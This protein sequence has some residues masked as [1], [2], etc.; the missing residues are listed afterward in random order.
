MKKPTGRHFESLKNVRGG[1]LRDGCVRLLSEQD[2]GD[3]FEERE[4]GAV[5][6]GRFRSAGFDFGEDLAELGV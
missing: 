5:P 4:G 1:F 2:L 3:V 6:A